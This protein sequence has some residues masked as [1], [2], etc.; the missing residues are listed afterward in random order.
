MLVNHGPSQK[1][2]K[3]E[4]KPWKWG[5]TAR[6]HEFHAK[7]ML[8][9]T[10]PFQDPA[11][12]RTTRRPDSRKETQNEILWTCLPFVRSG[13]NYLARQSERGKK[14]R[15][16]EEAVGTRSRNEQ[17][18]ISPTQRAVESREKWRKLVVKSFVVPQLPSQLRNSWRWRSYRDKIIAFKKQVLGVSTTSALLAIAVNTRNLTAAGA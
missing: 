11:G 10:K 14:T 7:T 12:I 3:E 1:P 4:Y 5:A 9:T 16:A 18:W 15:Q 17:A 2:C 13:Q 8:P 6:Y